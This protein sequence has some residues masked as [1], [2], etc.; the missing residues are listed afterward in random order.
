MTA[1]GPLALTIGEPASVAGEG[2]LT[3]EGCVYPTSTETLPGQ[4]TAKHLSWRA[5]V[6]GIDEP[7]VTAPACAHPGLGQADPSAT[8]A[9][10]TQAYATFRN[11][12]VYFH[13]LSDSPT[14]ALDDAGLA[15]LAG[16]L[17]SA[18]RTPSFS[19]IVP[20]RCHDASPGPCPGGGAGGVP[21]ADE[22][23]KQV[24]PKI[25]ASQAYK[26]GGLLVITS[27]EAPSSG[28]YADSSSCCGQPR[29]PNLPAA[30]G[31]AAALPPEGGGQVGALLLS[32]FVK[33]GAISQ[34]SFNHFSLLRTF[35]DLFGVKHLG[36]AAGAH[37]GSLEPSLF[38]AKPLTK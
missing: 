38:L 15:G 17:S 23:L 33:G 4:L 19:Y 18:K 10:A 26:H 22:L 5:Y 16:D 37:V 36:Y 25:L 21:G 8:G 28:E 13:A 3:G 31:S 27:D 32:P 6:Q 2:Q 34:E 1:A 30:T 29:F 9:T 11:P 12:F 20:D 35:E 14:C 7:G 24:V